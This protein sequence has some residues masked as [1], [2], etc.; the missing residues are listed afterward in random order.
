MPEYLGGPKMAVAA[1]ADEQ[2]ARVG[3]GHAGGLVGAKAHGLA[4]ETE[5]HVGQ[6]QGWG[7]KP[8]VRAEKVHQTGCNFVWEA[9]V[10]FFF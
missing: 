4:A 9:L 1:G 3:Q 10:C 7:R 5:G 6:R 8:P 2:V